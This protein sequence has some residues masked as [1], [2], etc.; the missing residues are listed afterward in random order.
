MAQE[1]SRVKLTYEDLVLL[2]DD[3]RRHELIDGEHF[4]T[5][6]PSTRHQ[7]ILTQL[8]VYLATYLREHRMGRV[9]PAPCDV[10][11][12]QFDVVEPDLLVVIHAV[13][14]RV[15]E[16]NIQGAPDLVVEILSHSTEG[17]DRGVKRKLYEKFGVREYWIV[18]PDAETVEILRLDAG[19]LVPVELLD[20][21]DTLTS[22]LFANLEIPLTAVFN[23]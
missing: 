12:S 13:D 14:D 2:P 20:C 18:D 8:L 11:L 3:G 23:D 10:V 16:A 4:V 9:F 7:Q 19:R 17:R 5:A 22:P 21:G 1:V 6:A 15:T